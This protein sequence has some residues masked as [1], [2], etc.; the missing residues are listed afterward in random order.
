VSQELSHKQAFEL[1]PWLV[2]DTLHG[3]ERERLERHV[4]DCL[5][6]R[7]DL[8]SQRALASL[9]Q[10]QATLDRSVDRGF[11][12]LLVRID[13]GAERA[14]RPPLW[15]T[16]L[17][18]RPALLAG[19]TATATAAVLVA[20]AVWLGG[21]RP[22]VDETGSFVTVTEPAANA[23]VLVDMIL[24]P[25]VSEMQMR[26]LLQELDLTIVAGPSE[27][28]RYTLRVTDAAPLGR[29]ALIARLRDDPRVR[30]A[31]P[32]FMPGQSE[33]AR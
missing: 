11:D 4:R 13:A 21:T 27:L 31:G 17:L 14:T 10:S 5:I 33:A 29:D 2:N 12:A 9:V 24:A 15:W 32:S 7:T 23:G 1:L 26:A 30:F 8:R 16:A 19:V 3:T 6:C 20:I 25:D 22:D 28:G 18:D